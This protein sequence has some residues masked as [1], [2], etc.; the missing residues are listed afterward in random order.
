MM[1]VDDVRAGRK[2]KR[3]MSNDSDDQYDKK[4]SGKAK[5]ARR[6]LTPA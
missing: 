1:D 3:S 5:S 2:R 6:S 4:S